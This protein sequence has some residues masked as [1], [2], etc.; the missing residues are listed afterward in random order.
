MVIYAKDLQGR[1]ILSNRRHSAILKREQDE[2]VGACEADLLPPDEAIAVTKISEQVIATG[3]T[4]QEEFLFTLEDGPHWALESVF[5][6]YDDAGELSAIGGTAMD[7]TERKLAEAAREEAELDR[8]VALHASQAKSEFLANMSHEIRTP[9]N[10]VIGMTGLLLETE[11][12]PQQRSFAEIV[13]KS[14]EVLLSLINDILDFSKIEAGELSVETVPMNIRE[15]VERSVELLALSAVNKGLE[16]SS[17]VAPDVPLALYGDPTRVQQTLVNLLNNAIKFT[18][19]GE[20]SVSVSVHSHTLEG[21]D[22]FAIEFAVR[23]TGL[24]IDPEVLPTLFD[25]FVQEDTSTTRRFGGT[26]LGLTICKRLAEAMGGRIWIES[27]QNVGTTCHFTIVGTLA[28]GTRPSYLEEE[29]P[30]LANRRVLVV[31]DNATNRK[32]LEHQLESWGVSAT[33]VR[34]GDAALAILRGGNN[35][36]C[37][38]FDMHM[39]SMD[40]LELAIRTRAMSAGK[41]LPLLMLTSLGQ[42]ENSPG[43]EEFSAF[44]TKPIKASRL[45]DVLLSVLHE[46]APHDAAHSARTEAPQWSHPSPVR[47]LVV[48]DNNIN[49][50]VALLSLERLGLR[51]SLASDGAEAVRAVEEV[52]YDLIFMDINMPTLDG[53]QATQR[54]RANPRIRQPFIAAVTANATVGDRR[55]C[56]E[57][58][59]DDYVSKPF[60]LN[61]LRNVLARFTA[62]TKDKDSGPVEP[63]SEEPEHSSP[64]PKAPA[65][66][67]LDRSAF[68]RIKELLGT[69]EDEELGEFIEQALVELDEELRRAI[70]AVARQD[71][72]TLAIAIHTFK[73]NARMIGAI[74]LGEAAK[75]IEA[76]AN[77]DDAQLGEFAEL[78]SDLNSIRARF[79]GALEHERKG[80]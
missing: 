14:G 40:G 25:A 36:D 59:M 1:F 20:V 49:Q 22:T 65:P 57:S 33:V 24:G 80:W 34:D 26:G 37:A 3:Q 38:I 16:L 46:S 52:A 54:I 48:E 71:R 76:R 64:T 55:K 63:R 12:D 56:I 51:A 74:E 28:P 2:I 47:V 77:D 45:Y 9:M 15:C 7:I 67:T 75:E 79:L 11:L 78:L 68:I 72:R 73:S 69:D 35:F 29:Q 42:R 10:A 21:D 43:M 13:R 5:P 53:L 58:G 17:V 50:R 41:R 18:E 32:I 6:M 8:D 61:D 70:D 39:P 27:K 31:D 4:V 66:I 62:W 23:D 60:R 19:D 30:L 44:L